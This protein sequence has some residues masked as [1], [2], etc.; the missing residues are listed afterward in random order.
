MISFA[1]IY[2]FICSIVVA[3]VKSDTTDYNESR[4]IMMCVLLTPVLYIVLHK[5]I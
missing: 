5:K 1:I 3:F 4:H 2:I